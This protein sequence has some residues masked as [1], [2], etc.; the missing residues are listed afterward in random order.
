MGSALRILLALLGG[1]ALGA[2]LRATDAGWLDTLQSIADPVGGLW[3]AALRMS[4]VPLVFALVITGIASASDR[5][6]AGGVA[7]RA[8]GLMIVL[9]TGS[10][11]L[12]AL[13][14][15]LLL[16]LWPILADSGAALRSV[17]PGAGEVPVAAIGGA[18]WQGIVPVNP[19]Q[20]AAEGAMLPLVVFAVALGFAITAI[21]A[22]ARE[23]LV[24]FFQALADALLVIV[25]WVLG[26]APVGVFALA[27]LLG[28]RTGL[29]AAGAL[30]HYVLLLIVLMGA[31]ALLVYPFAAIG[32]RLRPGVFARAVLPAQAVAASTQSSLASL[33]AMVEGCAGPLGVA[34]RVANLV[35]PLAVSVFRFSSPGVNLAVAI[36]GAHLY[37]L[38]P[39]ALQVATAIA[40]AVLTSMASVSLPGQ[41][42]FYTTATPLWLVLG[43]P[44]DLLPLLLAVETI[45]DIFRTI[46]NVTADVA[47]TAVV[48]RRFGVESG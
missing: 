14:F 45:P 36:Y 26:V 30:V 10:A 27:F 20:A 7:G 32:A 18:W 34:P 8:L 17:G 28:S 6:A 37:G 9:L 35:L 21:D 41:L 19:V 47:V 33:P 31:M 24:G 25:H 13:L 5:T 38:D 39:G 12:S 42:T 46:V 29:D 23:R 40:L 43:L 1:V 22:A 11:L 3:L 48:D 15:P 2:A 16:E 44:L 4:I